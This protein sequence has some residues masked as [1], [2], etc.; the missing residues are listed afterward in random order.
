LLL[1][2]VT[3]LYP[4]AEDPLDHQVTL[5]LGRFVMPGMNEGPGAARP[6]IDVLTANVLADSDR[7]YALGYQSIT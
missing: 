4:G 3:Q 6:F 5:C 1:D 2:E 7:T